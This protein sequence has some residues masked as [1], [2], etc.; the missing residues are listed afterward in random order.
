MAPSYSIKKRI[1]LTVLAAIIYFFAYV[2]IALQFT[3]GSEGHITKIDSNAIWVLKEN[4]DSVNA[5]PDGTILNKATYYQGIY[6]GTGELAGSYIN[7]YV[8]FPDSSETANDY[9]DRHFPLKENEFEYGSN[10]SYAKILRENNNSIYMML[11]ILLSDKNEVVHSWATENIE[12]TT[13]DIS[14]M[15]L[16]IAPPLILLLIW[17]PYEKIKKK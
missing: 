4:I 15:Y 1:I 2:C 17:I 9:I 12:Y 16:L 14:N 10:P 8:T 6:M 5:L 11:H 3:Y 7:I 13:Q